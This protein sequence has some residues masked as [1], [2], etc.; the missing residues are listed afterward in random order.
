[1][2]DITPKASK[3]SANAYAVSKAPLPHPLIATLVGHTGG[4][5]TLLCI[6][7]KNI[8]LSCANDFT[9]RSWDAATT[10][11]LQQFTGHS[12]YVRT[13]VMLSSSR[14]CSASEDHT[15]KIFE[16]GGSSSEAVA[17]LAGHKAGVWAVVEVGERIWSG[18]EDSSILVWDG[19]APY[20]LLETL[21][22]H[23]STV[24]SLLARQ[25]LVFSTSIDKC[26]VI[27]SAQSL[28]ILQRVQEHNGAVSG[29]LPIAVQKSE[30][31]WSWS[32][33]QT[34]KMWRVTTTSVGESDDEKLRALV[35]QLQAQLGESAKAQLDLQKLLDSAE[36]NSSQL[37][38][39]VQ[40][41]KCLMDEKEGMLQKRIADE[42]KMI[43]ELK[44][45]LDESRAAWQKEHQAV[46][47]QEM[48]LKEES[49]ALQKARA[50]L[51]RE[52]QAKEDESKRLSEAE[53]QANRLRADLA[54]SIGSS[55]EREKEL[56]QQLESEKKKHIEL[57]NQVFVSEA[58]F[59]KEL[60]NA[61]EA[62]RKQELAARE[63]ERALSEVDEA[64]RG[65][66]TI[67][68]GMQI[69]LRS[70]E[71]DL[72][73]E[74]L[75]AAS[76]QKQL[77]DAEKRLLLAQQKAQQKQELLQQEDVAL[78]EARKQLRDEAER[79]NA[80]QQ[81]LND[82]EANS[83]QLQAEVRR[84]QEAMRKK[85]ELLERQLADEEKMIGELKQSLD[86]SRAAWQ[87][88]H[89]DVALEAKRLQDETLKRKRALEELAKAR[90][91]NEQ[92]Q[93]MLATA[94]E[95]SHVVPTS[96]FDLDQS[97][98]VR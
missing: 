58:K 9:V 1:M 64:L 44:Q 35:K 33:D 73:A 25:Q 3:A 6:E 47:D 2:F 79:L 20:T 71:T 26:I 31:L 87:K 69:S 14:V 78:E 81:K 96:K 7:A 43:G 94:E 4:V 37:R 51:A 59:Q 86:E 80:V 53:A 91:E 77:D 74:H 12:N 76:L 45:S 18:G 88:E 54:A 8:V 19:S 61:D 57:K 32:S 15:L 10:S 39:D 68:E 29:L 56:A 21:K 92:L 16:V 36:A 60:A 52:H 22:G 63:R 83:S 72:E 5:Y 98:A 34:M 50:E 46:L 27:W 66:E 95:N 93:R 90:K 97:V 89:F 23:K 55:S 42:E 38:D 11:Q 70:A 82:A 17:T 41:T 75:L 28:S 62:L 48:R 84:L 85:E 13:V 40:R 67:L 24:V 49:V 30:L 65:K